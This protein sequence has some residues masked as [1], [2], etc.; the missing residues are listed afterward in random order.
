MSHIWIFTCRGVFG[1]LFNIS[2]K[3]GKYKT[4]TVRMLFWQC[5]QKLWQSTVHFSCSYRAKVLNLLPWRSSPGLR[6]NGKDLKHECPVMDSVGQ[7]QHLSS[8]PCGDGM[9]PWL[10]LLPPCQKEIFSTTLPMLLIHS[11]SNRG[12]LPTYEIAFSSLLLQFTGKKKQTKPVW[13]PDTVT[14]WRIRTLPC[15]H[16]SNLFFLLLSCALFAK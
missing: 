4:E 11:A 10:P 5:L 8:A 1:F 3:K 6:C 2:Q 15:H 12:P 9:G 7:G 16:F 14:S 13:G